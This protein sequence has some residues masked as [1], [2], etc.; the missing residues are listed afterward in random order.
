MHG[1]LNVKYDDT[2]TVTTVKMPPHCAPHK[3]SH[4]ILLCRTGYIH[5]TYSSTEIIMR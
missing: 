3:T 5:S 1:H 2:V 4:S